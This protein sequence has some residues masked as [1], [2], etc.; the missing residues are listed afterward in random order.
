[1]QS[2]SQKRKFVVRSD[3]KWERVA[4]AEV[5]VPEV[6]NVAGDWWSREAIVAAAYMFMEQ[7]F[8]LDLEH[9]NED[10][11]GQWFVVESFVARPGDPDFIEGSWVVGVRVYNDDIW[12]KILSGEING[13]SYEAMIYYLTGEVTTDDDFVRQGTT[14]P[15]VTGDFHTHDFAVMVDENNRP[16]RGGTTV[17]NGHYHDILVHS[18]TEESAGHRHRYNLING[19][20]GK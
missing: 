9:D 7:G 18:I 4:F 8:K 1:M 2:S 3:T 17:D 13:F 12:N 6:R 15:D 14:E 16:V 19:K 5:L 11:T 10:Y 20:D